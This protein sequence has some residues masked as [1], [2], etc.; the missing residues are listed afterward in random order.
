ME[1]RLRKIKIKVIGVCIQYNIELVLYQFFVHPFC[2]LFLAST[3]CS[4]VI[5][6][7][8]ERASIY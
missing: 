7:A 4:L 2:M 8:R 6:C 5:L 3:A 1:R